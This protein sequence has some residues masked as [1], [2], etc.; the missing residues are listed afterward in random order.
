MEAISRK[1]ECGSGLMIV[2]SENLKPVLIGITE[3]KNSVF[4]F[5]LLKWLIAFE[6]HYDA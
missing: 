3:K 4:F 6:L 1:Q 5:S 2:S